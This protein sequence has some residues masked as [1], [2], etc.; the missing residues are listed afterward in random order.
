MIIDS[1]GLEGSDT[2]PD[3]QQ[4]AQTSAIVSGDV[5]GPADPPVKQGQFSSN[6]GDSGGLATE[7]V[8]P[9]RLE[10]TG[11]VTDPSENLFEPDNQRSENPETQQDSDRPENRPAIQAGTPITSTSQESPGYTRT[12]YENRSIA[13]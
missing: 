10:N 4:T 1:G 5:Q 6:L 12:M 8:D 13:N 9:G 11:T 2:L 7:S 3:E